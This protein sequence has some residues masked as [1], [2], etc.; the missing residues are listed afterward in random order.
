MVAFAAVVVAIVIIATIGP[1]SSATGFSQK[2]TNPPL[3]LV[4][5]LDKGTYVLGEVLKVRFTLTNIGREPILLTFPD[6]QTFDFLIKDIN[7]EVVHKWS[8]GWM[9]AQVIVERSLAPGQ[10]I[11]E[12]LSWNVGVSGLLTLTGY[13]VTFWI[14][15]WVD[16]ERLNLTTQ[17]IQ[18]EVFG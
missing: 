7:G 10:S 5:E 13:T 16:G 17:P 9:F 11:Q 1:L 14:G 18:F 6:T 12:I 8:W 3:C 4:V 15:S 2:V